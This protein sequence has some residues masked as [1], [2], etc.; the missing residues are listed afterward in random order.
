MPLTTTNF[1]DTTTI[2]PHPNGPANFMLV[3]SLTMNAVL[4]ISLVVFFIYKI[5]KSCHSQE[6]RAAPQNQ[7]TSPRRRMP[8][9]LDNAN[10]FFSI[11][12]DDESNERNLTI[13]NQPLL[14]RALSN[15]NFENVDLHSPLRL[16]PF[17]AQNPTPIL[18]PQEYFLLRSYK[19]FKPD[20][21]SMS[22]RNQQETTV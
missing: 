21:V 20:T 9:L 11:G 13:E 22:Q 1:P 7:I 6:N 16:Q 8:P 10:H 19:T 17:Q 14:P 2:D 12:S 18:H 3:G 5:W 4:V 15:A